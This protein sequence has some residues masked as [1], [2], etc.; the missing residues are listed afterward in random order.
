MTQPVGM[1]DFGAQFRKHV[2]CSGLAGSNSPRQSKITHRFIGTGRSEVLSGELTL[3]TREA[4]LL[5]RRLAR[6]LRARPAPDARGL[7]RVGHEHGDRQ[8][9][10]SAGHGRVSSRLFL[11]VLRL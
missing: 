8:G 3:A 10:N 7:D 1:N 9:T 11:G 2:G 4:A 5:S 6:E